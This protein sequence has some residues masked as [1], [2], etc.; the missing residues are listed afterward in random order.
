MSLFSFD[1]FFDQLYEASVCSLEVTCIILHQIQCDH[2]EF[3]ILLFLVAL[4]WQTAW[5]ISVP[6]ELLKLDLGFFISPTLLR[7]VSV[8][9]SELKLDKCPKAESL[10]V[11]PIFSLL[12]ESSSCSPCCPEPRNSSYTYLAACQYQLFILVKLE[13]PFP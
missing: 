3:L 2:L 8:P 9:H 7:S 6:F 4:L 10:V 11:E 1:R 12:G 13:S 5:Q